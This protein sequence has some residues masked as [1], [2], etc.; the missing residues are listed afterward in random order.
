MEG[1]LA[2]FSLLICPDL[3]EM[4]DLNCMDSFLALGPNIG[5]QYVFLNGTD[6]LRC[7]KDLFFNSHVS[8]N[9]ASQT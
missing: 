4:S 9:F 2:P 3:I 5:I 7:T 8:S 1:K 6:V